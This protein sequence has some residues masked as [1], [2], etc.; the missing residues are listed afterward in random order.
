MENVEQK[1]IE[2][3]DAIAAKLGTGVDHFWPLFVQEQLIQGR[4]GLLSG[5]AILLAT[6]FG[7]RFMW[8]HIS[9]CDDD[10]DRTLGKFI[11]CLCALV[12][13]SMGC[14]TLLGAEKLINPEYHALKAVLEMVR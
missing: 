14:V 9:K 5:L 1:A 12:F 7:A 3:L 4:I 8:L 11:L 13:T 10:M 6:G 2:I